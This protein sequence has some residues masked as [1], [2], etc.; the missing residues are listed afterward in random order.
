MSK[1]KRKFITLLAV[2]LCAMLAL[3]TAILFIPKKAATA[4]RDS[5][6]FYMVND[7][8]NDLWIGGNNPFNADVLKKLY[9]ALVGNENATYDTLKTTLDSGS[10]SNADWN[11]T[12]FISSDKIR[13]SN[14]VTNN[15]NVSIWF[16]GFKWDVTFITK[17]VSGAN[18]IL[19]LWMSSEDGQLL[20]GRKYLDYRVEGCHE[21]K[22]PTNM[23]STSQMRV[24][25][26]NIGGY[27]SVDTSNLSTKQPQDATHPY[28]HFTMANPNNTHQSVID[29][30]VQP[31]NVKYQ[32]NE[33]ASLTNKGLICPNDAYG[34]PAGGSYYVND[35]KYGDYV[36]KGGRATD[37][38]DSYDAGL[39][40]YL[41]AYDDW[42]YDYLW[43]PSAAE[44]G[45]TEASNKNGIWK[46]NAALRSSI[47]SDGAWLRSGNVGASEDALPLKSSGEYTSSYVNTPHAVRPAIHLNLTKANNGSS[48][49]LTVPNTGVE[50]TY[51]G[52]ALT[53]SDITTVPDW[54]DTDLYADSPNADSKPITV[55]YPNGTNNG[56]EDMVDATPTGGDGYEIEATV[57]SDKYR[58][59]D[60]KTNSS[61]TRK[62]KYKINKKKIKID[63][64]TDATTHLPEANINKPDDIKSRDGTADDI[65]A[66]LYFK[67]KSADGSTDYG[68][69]LP[70]T[71]S[72]AIKPATYQAIICIEDDC[73]YTVSENAYT[74]IIPKSSSG[75]NADD[76][77]WVYSN[78][79]TLNA[80]IDTSTLVNSVFQVTYN[81]NQYVIKLDESNL[82]DMGVK[83]KANSYSD[84]TGTTVGSH[85]ASV[86]LE[87]ADEEYDFP[88][89]IITLK[90]EITK[91]KY[92]LSQIEWDYS[93]GSLVYDG[94]EHT[95]KVK[96]LPAGLS[97]DE[98]S[99]YTGHKE[100]NATPDGSHYTAK[101]LSFINADTVN[102]ETPNPNDADTFTGNTVAGLQLEWKIEKKTLTVEWLSRDNK[103][104]YD[105]QSQEYFWLPVPTNNTNNKFEVKYYREE[106]FDTQSLGP[107]EGAAAVAPADMH[108]SHVNPER[109]YAVV[110]L[111]ADYL[112][113]HKVDPATGF[114]PFAAGDNRT[115]VR[116]TLD[117]EFTFDNLKHGT[118]DEI[119]VTV[120][121]DGFDK[122][123]IKVEWY[124][125]N[126]STFNNVGAPLS[127]AP[128]D[129][130][131]YF[132][133]FTIYPAYES[134]YVIE[135]S[136]MCQFEIKKLVLDVPTFSGTLT[137]DGTEQDVAELVG[138]P[139]DWE[140]YLEITIIRSGGGDSPAGHTVKNA[141][142]YTVSF[143]IKDGI[144]SG[145]ANNV[146]W[147]TPT[148]K[149][150]T[151]T[152]SPFIVN[153]L[154]L[155]A[156]SWAVDGY[157]TTL[158][159][160][161]E[162]AE[163]FVN[164]KVL[165]ANGDA[166]D[167]TAFYGAGGKGFTVEV[168]VGAEHGDNVT[169]EFA[170]GITSQYE[171]PA[172]EVSGNG[173]DDSGENSGDNAADLESKKKAA[174]EELEKA[175]QAKKES[176]DSNPDLTDEEKAAAKAEV[177]RE[178]EAGKKAIDDANDLN[179][180]QSAESLSKNNIENINPEHKGSFP[181][182]IL[183]VAAGVLLLLIL[184]IIVIVKRR[185][186]ADGDEDFY[187]EDYDFDEEDYEEEDF[188]DDF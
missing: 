185:Q 36:N 91:A 156:K 173:G 51:T 28:A 95:V 136:G 72:G 133:V 35:S 22:Y 186:T 143:K 101:I 86:T 172:D 120:T 111:T 49:F 108:V 182:W 24:I 20:T 188:G 45:D 48:E 40:R 99:G 21:D 122:S 59:A 180:V 76:L 152:I 12:R 25:E 39:Q 151:K 68:K 174:K 61:A 6:A 130:G 9:K 128:K 2:L 103:N 132:A 82:S 137:Y 85:T 116:V 77:K 63:I 13:G 118:L 129:V 159:F 162:S 176:I 79:S 166:V 158:V 87:A 145:T 31:K 29:Y 57:I 88:D 114:M 175:A 69:N 38:D 121:D 138:L 54:Y 53:M 127:D 135:G 184:L 10:I 46:T 71:Q 98:S 33:Y 110:F 177:D 81:A 171:F 50:S 150:L 66:K 37:P 43:L 73:N 17:D 178:L 154:V 163:K 55:T 1:L 56:K 104:Q 11:G 67:Y 149:T 125:Y 123:Y 165:N 16:A 7:A 160:N 30:L 83:V 144:N 97:I 18:I 142:S 146:E 47:A 84:Y 15:K 119:S 157:Y 155:H 93:T 62:F 147:N 113:N 65:K 106:D 161:E 14:S 90:W 153:Q 134:T 27:Y 92:D 58:W 96:T 109:Y 181:W 60:Y 102:Y 19:D 107:K 179:G 183:A 124:E 94:N 115:V 140:N 126:S 3:S 74:F 34:T 105:A 168:S 4:A 42:K 89:T 164:Y 117:K 75:F 170:N 52:E 112:L 167:A 78:G 169:I 41:S 100:T 32:E 139:E 26:L 80:E 5:S 44:T 8:D 187:D 131:K 23:Y 70:T 141:G 148:N 64:T